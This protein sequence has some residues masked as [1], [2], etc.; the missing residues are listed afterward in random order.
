MGK[1]KKT[2]MGKDADG[3]FHPGKGK[4]SGINKEEGL[5]LHP[6]S[7]EKLEEYLELTD[8]Y[9]TGEDTLAENVPVRH[10][11]RNTSKGEDTFKGKENK[12]ES[13]KSKNETFTEDRTT[14]IPEQLP[15][16]LTK[17]RFTE[18]A[19]YRSDCTV[20]LYIPTHRAGVEVNEHFDA[21][22]F[23]NTLNT[24][25][26]MLREKGKDEGYIQNLLKPG[27]DLIRDDAFWKDLTEG[28][29]L[30][31]A[32][33]FFK[34]IKM[35][36]TPESKIVL[37][38]TFYVTPLIPIM[39]SKEYFYL[40]VISK[41]KVKL[42]KADAFGMQP[43][44]VD[45][46]DGIDAVKRLSGLDAT[47]YRRGESGRRA[48]G[49]SQPGQSHGG[50]GG[51]PDGKDNLATYFEAVD[52][53]LWDEVFKNEKNAPLMLAGVEYEI[54]IYKGVCDYHNVWENALTGSR[55]HQDTRSLY[56]D[57]REVMEPYFQQR[58]TKALQ[59]Y[60]NRS[61][62]TLTSTVIEELVPAAHYGRIAQLFV[63]KDV[64][65][66]GSFDETSG[67]V[68]M[69]GAQQAD[70]ED[71]VDHTVVKTL[72]TGGEVFLLEKSQMPS[73]GCLAA[74]LRY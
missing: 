23:K 19:D 56:K 13:D 32:D 36:A 34:Y 74:L 52:D 60:G 30:F 3:T 57:A 70:S 67:Q 50:G 25:E 18:L 37:E 4:P 53:I 6:T 38:A 65:V 35:P 26:Q 71:L 14:T 9:T 49:V 62:T 69:H 7:P 40:L 21:I 33:G 20:S 5:G 51:N 41:H 73:D 72:S 12:E 47:T 16:I 54:P 15:G 22:S 58:T 66:W 45:L 68:I 42:F 63:C 27:Y 1:D 59:T 11:N 39:T 2:V 55:E 10:K 46:P 28:L 8:K 24:V 17:E 64:H 29:A 48:P 44:V 31:I 43:V 61:A